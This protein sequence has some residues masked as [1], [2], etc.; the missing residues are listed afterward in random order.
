MSP[1]TLSQRRRVGGGGGCSFAA[2]D[3]DNTSLTNDATRGNLRKSNGGRVGSG[4]WQL[5]DTQR[6]SE[7]E[8]T[9]NRGRGGEKKKKITWRGSAGERALPT[10]IYRASWSKQRR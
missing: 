9:R 10:S 7:E 4:E 5:N 2:G 1:R 8:E 6:Q 3:E